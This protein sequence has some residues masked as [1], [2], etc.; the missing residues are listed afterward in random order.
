[1]FFLSVFFLNI[2]KSGPFYSKKYACDFCVFVSVSVEND[3]N[4]ILHIF[5][6]F[7]IFDF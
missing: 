4:P 2:Q 7:C 5:S 1:M 6:F 3:L